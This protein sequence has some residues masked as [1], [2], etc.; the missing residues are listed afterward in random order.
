MGRAAHFGGGDRTTSGWGRYVRWASGRRSPEPGGG[1]RRRRR[2][3]GRRWAGGIGTCSARRWSWW[4]SQRRAAGEAEATRR[5]RPRPPP[6]RAR[7]PSP[8]PRRASSPTSRPSSPPTRATGTPGW[9]AND[10]PNPDHPDLERYAT[11]A[12]L[13][14][15]ASRSPITVRWVRCSDCLRT[16]SPSTGVGSSGSMERPRRS[17]TVRSMTAWSSPMA[18]AIVLDDSVVTWGFE[19]VLGLQEGGGLCSDFAFA[20]PVGGVSGCAA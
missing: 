12:A 18:V 11:G 19:V 20:D 7:P 10:P 5:R 4:S 9:P 3:A 16:R 13:A 15:C 1:A 2:K 14:R 17:S 6:G 8:P